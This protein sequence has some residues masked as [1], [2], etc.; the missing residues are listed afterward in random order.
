MTWMIRRALKAPLVTRSLLRR[1]M[2]A[3]GGTNGCNVLIY[4]R[5]DGS[6]PL[7][8]DL[9]P[10]LFRRQLEF[11]AKATRVV[12]YDAALCEL[13]GPEA[14][15]ASEAAYPPTALTF[16]DGYVDFYTR[17][18]PLLL[19]CNV[20]ATLFVTTG[21][22]EERKP[23]PMLS[24]PDAAVEP[25]TWEMLGEMAES[26]L[27]TLG[28]HTHT[29]PVL[30]RLPIAQVEEE[31]AYPLEL[32]ERRLGVRPRHFAYPR[33]EANPAL[34]TL[35]ARHYASG[36]VGGGR[37]AVPESFDRYAVPR[38]PIRRSDG[39]RFFRAKLRGWLDD[40]EVVYERLRRMAGGSTA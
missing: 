17:V 9:D 12:G 19:Q 7:E 14:E 38:I 32:F 23:Y 39:W 15:P 37:R 8:L 5:V 4:H 21:F 16:D 24:R 34:R 31:L 20:P 29:H 10:E 1:G 40:E 27:V 3:D 33:A 13:A 28:A 11:I 25:V 36:A 35:V 26:G 22:V 30:T 6:L 2:G 18:Y